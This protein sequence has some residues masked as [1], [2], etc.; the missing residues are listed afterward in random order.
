[1]KICPACLGVVGLF[2][3][4]INCETCQG[5]VVND[6]VPGIGKFKLPELSEAEIQIQVMQYLEKAVPPSK[7]FFYRSSPSR[8][9]RGRPYHQSE[10]GQPDIVL[11]YMG[12]YVGIEIKVRKGVQSSGQMVFEACVEQAGGEYYVVRSLEEMQEIMKEVAG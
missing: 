9:G 10:T 3:V 11:I 4:K 8:P 1:M 5:G 7:G 6:K 2:G 12:K